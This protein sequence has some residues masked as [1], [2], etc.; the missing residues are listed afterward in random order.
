MLLTLSF[1]LNVILLA[2]IIILCVRYDVIAKL[3]LAIFK[4]KK[5]LAK[6]YNELE[7]LKAIHTIYPKRAVDVLVFGDSI[8]NTLDWRELSQGGDVINFAIGGSEVKDVLSHLSV[9]EGY[10]PQRIVIWVGVN[11]ALRQRPVSQTID[12]FNRLFE[13]LKM[14][15]VP[16]VILSICKTRLD[17]ANIAIDLCNAFLE[18]NASLYG[19]QYK[20][21]C[22]DLVSGDY[23]DVDFTYDGVHL[24]AAAYR[25]IEPHILE[26]FRA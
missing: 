11:D 8:A 22:S 10:Q 7:E 17:K 3:Q 20:D 18:Q 12:C 9:L 24:N 5:P 23:L 15:S 19:G 26:T 14:T 16:F 25:H 1:L 2:G 4:N 13:T 6:N 21:I